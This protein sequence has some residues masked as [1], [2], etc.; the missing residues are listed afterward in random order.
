MRGYRQIPKR[1]SAFS[2]GDEPV[3]YCHHGEQKVYCIPE[4]D[5]KA[6]F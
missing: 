5:C 2:E 3:E 4:I 1:F 6:D